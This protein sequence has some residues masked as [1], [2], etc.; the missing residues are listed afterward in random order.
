MRVERIA[1]TLPQADAEVLRARIQASHD[2]IE[3]AQRAYRT[4]QDAIR[5]TL[6]KDPF[7]AAA[8]RD[9]MAK[10]RAARQ[11]F[12]QIIQG[13]FA[14]AAAGDVPSRPAR[15]G[16]L[17]AR[18]QIREQSSLNRARF[19]TGPRASLKVAGMRRGGFVSR[20]GTKRRA[21][22]FVSMIGTIALLLPLGGCLLGGDR[23]EPALDIPP[24]YTR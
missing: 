15:L 19:R 16:R 11:N 12:D 8:M 3:T 14:S 10:T 23:P 5:A 7:E 24:S 13:V 17:A 4:D 9:A 1:A 6:R 2:A 18:A 20:K 22:Q 21:R